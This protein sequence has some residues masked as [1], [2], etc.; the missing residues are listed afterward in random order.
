MRIY[1]MEGILN[2]TT[3]T[4]HKQEIGKSGLETPSWATYTLPENQLRKTTID[5]LLSTSTATKCGRCFEVGGG[6]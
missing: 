5:Q 6:Y 4:V 3:N 1:S 2:E